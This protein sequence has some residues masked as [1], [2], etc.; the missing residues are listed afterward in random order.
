MASTKYA[1]CVC[2]W[3]S[4]ALQVK[5]VQVCLIKRRLVWDVAMR[6]SIFHCH[7]DTVVWN[8]SWWAHQQQWHTMRHVHMRCF[9]IVFLCK[10]V[11]QE[12]LLCEPAHDV[13]VQRDKYWQIW[14]KIWIMQKWSTVCVWWTHNELVLRSCDISPSALTCHSVCVCV[15]YRPAGTDG[16]NCGRSAMFLLML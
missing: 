2:V 9:Y 14:Y 16:L 10:H 11:L 3:S 8:F 1:L 15:C 6:N 5:Y 13:N 12:H 4:H 7:N